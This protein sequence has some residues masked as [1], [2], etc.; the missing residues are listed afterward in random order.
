MSPIDVIPDFI[1]VLGMLDDLFVLTLVLRQ[2]NADLEKYRA[3]KE[4]EVGRE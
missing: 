4:G 2:V 1:P 3:W